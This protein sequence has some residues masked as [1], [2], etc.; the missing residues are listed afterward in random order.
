[1]TCV[2]V[3]KDDTTAYTGSKDGTVISWDA[4]TGQRKYILRDRDAQ[5]GRIAQVLAVAV[6]TDGKLLAAAGHDS[7][8]RISCGWFG[9]KTINHGLYGRGWLARSGCG[10]RAHKRS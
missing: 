2:A 1:M 5:K 7:L 8:V 6:S 3:A 9:V 4:A 10:I